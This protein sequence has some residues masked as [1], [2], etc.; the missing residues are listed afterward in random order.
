MPVMLRCRQVAVLLGPICHAVPW[1]PLA[2]AAGLSLLVLLPSLLADPVP[3]AALTGLRVAA[4][5]L[6]AGA[7]FAM[8]D[9]MAPATVAPTPRWLRQWLRLVVVVV[10]AVAVW[11]VLHTV[12]V[13]VLGP[14]A[15]GPVR[16]IAVEAATC[17]LAGLAGA[18]VGGRYRHTVVG[19]LAGPMTQFTLI[20]S[21]HFIAEDYSAWALPNNPHWE[22]IHRGWSIGLL[23]IVAVLVAANRDTRGPSR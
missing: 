19:A 7:A 13:A 21:T 16:D 12:A 2:G 23:I 20:V 22:T 17:G 10:P 5:M 1:L 6:G 3:Y 8:V 4:V 15:T 9:P 14:T 11:S 18:A